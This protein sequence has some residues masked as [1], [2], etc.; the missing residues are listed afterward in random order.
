MDVLCEL[1]QRLADT[2]LFLAVEEA[3]DRGADLDK[4]GRLRSARADLL[5]QIERQQSISPYLRR[6]LRSEPE[7]RRDAERGS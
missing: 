3:A 1:R 7:A 5:L 6:H 4:I 2:E